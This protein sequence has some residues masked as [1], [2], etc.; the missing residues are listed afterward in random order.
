[1]LS[2][3]HIATTGDE[4]KSPNSAGFIPQI[5]RSKAGGKKDSGAAKT[6]KQGKNHPSHSC[7]GN[8]EREGTSQRLIRGKV[9]LVTPMCYKSRIFSGETHL[10]RILLEQGENV[11]FFFHAL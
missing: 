5:P 6:A 11:H 10:W 4:E 1:M 3:S 2:L 7:V 9:S 8:W